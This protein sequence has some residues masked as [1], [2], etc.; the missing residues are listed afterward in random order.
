ME[1]FCQS[2]D[3]QCH[4]CG[5]LRL[6]NKVLSLFIVLV[7]SFTLVSIG[8]GAVGTQALSD[9]EVDKAADQVKSSLERIWAQLDNSIDKQDL[10][11]SVSKYANPQFRNL[12]KVVKHGEFD[13]LARGKDIVYHGYREDTCTGVSAKEFSNR[14][15]Y[16]SSFSDMGS[17]WFFSRICKFSDLPVGVGVDAAAEYWANLNWE[18]TGCICKAYYDPKTTSMISQSDIIRVQE[19]YMSKYGDLY[20]ETEHDTEEVK[21]KKRFF[22]LDNDNLV[23][24]QIRDRVI[25]ELLSKQAI[26]TDLNYEEYY[27]LVLDRTILTFDEVDEEI[28]CRPV[29]ID[30]VS[31]GDGYFRIIDADVFTVEDRQYRVKL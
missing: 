10:I 31:N 26:V 24:H 22:C 8:A 1:S 25:A 2:D 14:F 23:D 11:G 15:K 3:S 4:I 9:D 19:R 20:R 6:A 21:I 17:G 7:M 18:G 27:V 29:R 13:E 5:G 28:A 16:D 30:L 12:P